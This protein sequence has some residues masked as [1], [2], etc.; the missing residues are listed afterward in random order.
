MNNWSEYINI[1]H[2]KLRSLCYK[3]QVSDTGPL[4]LLLSLNLIMKHN[5]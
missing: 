5:Q 2:V 1:W 4:R 3:N